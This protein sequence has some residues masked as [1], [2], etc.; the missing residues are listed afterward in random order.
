MVPELVIRQMTR[1]ELDT[2]VEWA[3]NEGWNPGLNDAQ[4]FWDTDPEGFVAAELGG[5]LIGGGSIV[6]YGGRF[7]FMGF[8]IIRPDCRSQGLGRRL[9]FHRRDLLIS[10]LQSPAVVGM[11]GVFDMQGFYRRGG[12]ILF[13]RDLR[14][15]GVGAAGAYADTLVDLA[16][17]PF[18]EVARYDAAHFPAPRERYLKAWITQAGSRALGAVQDG[19]LRGYGVIRPCRQGFKI[20]PLFAADGESAEALFLGLGD[21]APGEPIFL[22]VPENNPEAMALARRHGLREI[23]GCARMYYGPPPVLPYG[24]IFGVTTFELG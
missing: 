8:F 10:R 9:W 17:V 23:F 24:E 4:I 18:A 21:I 12:F 13:N 11:D 3:A 2:L 6:S 20:G 1:T 15:E 22:D 19:V 16:S 14:F 5:E 7:G